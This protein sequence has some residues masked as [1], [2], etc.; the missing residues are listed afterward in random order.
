MKASVASVVV[1]AVVITAHMVTHFFTGLIPALA[2][3]IIS[4]MKLT[5]AQWGILVG[6]GTFITGTFQVMPGILARYLR[7]KVILGI[8]HTIMSAAALIM[9]YSQGFYQFLMGQ[10]VYGVGVSPQH[11][12]GTTIIAEEFENSKG[13]AFGS[14]FGLAFMGN[15]VGPLAVAVLVTSVG[16]REIMSLF[17]LPPLL[18]ALGVFLLPLQ[19]S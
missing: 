16:W 6:S 5:V 8:G 4:D 18:V 9:G 14:F 12:I 1:L 13:G 10:I 19:G 17:A 3:F 11:P 15:L 7:K 2:P